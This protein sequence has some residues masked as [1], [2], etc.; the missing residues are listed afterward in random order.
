MKPLDVHVAQAIDFDGVPRSEV[1]L[2]LALTPAVRVSKHKVDAT[3]AI[4]HAKLLF[5]GVMRKHTQH[6]GG[7]TP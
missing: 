6:L 2:D 4:E 5:A 3:V 1:V 7:V